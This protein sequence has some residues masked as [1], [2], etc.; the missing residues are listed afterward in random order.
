[1]A[2]NF[3]G[4]DRFHHRKSLLQFKLR[5]INKPIAVNNIQSEF[6]PAGGKR[7][8]FRLLSALLS[9]LKALFYI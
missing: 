9:F 5:K 2:E 6:H 4:P 1:M 8:C 3:I 7:A